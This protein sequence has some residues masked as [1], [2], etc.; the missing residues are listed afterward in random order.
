LGNRYFSGDTAPAKVKSATIYFTYDFGI[1][2]D[3]HHMGIQGQN[4]ATGTRRLAP[5]PEI[6]RI[7]ETLLFP[8]RV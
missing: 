1:Q 8:T 2:S 7:S 6:S 4:E 5:N 3:Y